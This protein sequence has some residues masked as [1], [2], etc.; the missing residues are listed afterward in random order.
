MDNIIT[1]LTNVLNTLQTLEIRS[2]FDT[3]NKLLGCMKAIDN[4]IME[5]SKK[6]QRVE[7]EPPVNESEPEVEVEEMTVGGN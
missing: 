5:L 2:D 7:P 6:N 4:S 1:E 3:M